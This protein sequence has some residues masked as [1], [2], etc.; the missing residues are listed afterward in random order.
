[1]S[2]LDVAPVR[3]CDTRDEPYRLSIVIDEMAYRLLRWVVLLVHAQIE[4]HPIIFE[5][6]VAHLSF[7]GKINLSENQRKEGWRSAKDEA[8]YW[9][10]F[11]ET[12]DAN[13]PGSS[14]AT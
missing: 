12:G 5:K 4:K 9:Y 1:M 3:E 8:G 10:A 13:E 14:S 6:T 11:F 2:L 7:S